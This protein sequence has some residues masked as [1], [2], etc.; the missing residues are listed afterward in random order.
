[1]KFPSE[2]ELSKIR[3]KLS[4][5]EGSLILSKTATPLEKFRYEICRQFVIYQRE[6]NL[7]SKELAEILEIDDSI[8]SKILH[9]RNERF[10]TDKLIHLLAKIYP[11]HHLV[12]KVS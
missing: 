4:K 1:M 7:K 8:M 5:S 3:K 12:L 10:S 6:N 2:K 11:K 9:Y